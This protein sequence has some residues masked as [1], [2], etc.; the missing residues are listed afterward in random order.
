VNVGLTWH[1]PQRLRMG[2]AA[3]LAQFLSRFSASVKN[4]LID[5]P[6]G[7]KPVPKVQAEIPKRFSTKHAYLSYINNH[8]RPKWGEFSLTQVKPLAVR[9]W[10]KAILDKKRQASI[11]QQNERSHQR[12]HAPDLRLR[13][14]V[15]VPA[16]GP[17][18]D[19][20]GA[21]RG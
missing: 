4:V 15:G 20:S 19:V 14:A 10:L 13:H 2:P 1:A 12:A 6:T 21:N 18:S 5:S 9:D 7:R 3:P 17:Q 11:G 8:I 16:P